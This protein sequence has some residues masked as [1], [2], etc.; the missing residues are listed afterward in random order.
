MQLLQQSRP[1]PSPTLLLPLID[2]SCF[3]VSSPAAASPPK[4]LSWT[5]L[6]RRS[7]PK[8]S[9]R[10]RSFFNLAGPTFSWISPRS[11]PAINLI[12][13]HFQPTRFQPN[14]NSVQPLWISPSARKN[15]RS[16]DQAQPKNFSRP[17]PRI[18][19][20][21]QSFLARPKYPPTPPKIWNL[22][23]VASL[24]WCPGHRF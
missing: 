12:E 19:V 4:S 15:F 6:P 16:P 14:F 21:L 8:L 9:S 23:A 3:L 22:A 7:C 24:S 18:S 20:G 13:A 11:S 10:T 2:A 1:K 5:S 17:K